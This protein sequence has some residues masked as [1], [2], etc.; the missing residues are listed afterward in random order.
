MVLMPRCR[1][2]K[3]CA[4]VQ[5]ARQ[6]GRVW[7]L[8]KWAAQRQVVCKA[9]NLAQLAQLNTPQRLPSCSLVQ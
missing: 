4:G 9:I 3:S 8:T 6:N 2:M 1:S 5:G 7:M